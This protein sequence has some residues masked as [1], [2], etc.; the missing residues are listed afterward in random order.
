MQEEITIN[1]Q[2]YVLK[3]TDAPA[4]QLDGLPYVLIRGDRSGVFVGYLKS[5]NKQEATLLRA[6]RIWYWAGAASISQLAINGTSN[7]DECKFPAEVSQI[8]L[9]DVIE[10]LQ[11]TAKAKASIK[12]VAVWQQ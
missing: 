6:R 2:V 3:G 7:P 5:R 1:G 8:E 4:P 10:V 11:V 9:T 12:G